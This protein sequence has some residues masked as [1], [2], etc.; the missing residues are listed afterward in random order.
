[1]NP[2]SFNWWIQILSNVMWPEQK[3]WTW[4]FYIELHNVK[5][6]TNFVCFWKHFGNAW[7]SEDRK[8]WRDQKSTVEV[9]QTSQNFHTNK[10]P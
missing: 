8:I 1:M 10:L 6:I 7:E 9:V 5:K 4:H 2:V 3:N